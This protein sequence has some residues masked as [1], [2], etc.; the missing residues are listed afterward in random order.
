MRC[1]TEL[2]LYYHISHCMQRLSSQYSFL[3]YFIVSYPDQI[4]HV[5][6][7]G[8]LGMIAHEKFGLGTRSWEWEYCLVLCRLKYCVQQN[9]ATIAVLLLKLPL[10]GSFDYIVYLVSFFFFGI[11]MLFWCLSGWKSSPAPNC[12]AKAFFAPRVAVT[13]NQPKWLHVW[14]FSN[15]GLWRYPKVDSQLDPQFLGKSIS[16]SH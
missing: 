13:T 12:V 4:I 3:V 11:V 14:P 6:C 7:V 10:H 1:S 9:V 15:C 16:L 5:H 8:L 2:A